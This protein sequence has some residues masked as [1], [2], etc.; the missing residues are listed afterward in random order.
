MARSACTALRVRP[1][2]LVAMAACL[3]LAAAPVLAAPGMEV[4]PT[5]ATRDL[6]GPDLALRGPHH[7]VAPRTQVREFMG[8][9]R[10]TT[11]LGDIDAVG[12]ADL[13]DRIGEAPALDALARLE[14]SDA[15]KG[16][17]E[18]S[19]RN[20][21][22]SARRVV[23]QP[24]ETI[25]S[26]P[27]GVGRTLL[28]GGR[29]VRKVALD[30]ADAVTPGD[31]DP[32]QD[33]AQAKTD[34]AEKNG[35][36]DGSDR[37]SGPDGAKVVR[38]YA[39]ELA[40]VNR[41]RRRIAQSLGIDPYP[42]S[43]LVADKLESLAWAG[44]AGGASLDLAL[45][46]VSS[47]LRNTVGVVRDVDQLAWDLP[48]ADVRHQLEKRLRARGLAGRASRDWLRNR[49]FTP[50]TQLQ[51]VALLE[52]L[53]LRDGEGDLLAL[54]TQ[55]G[56]PDHARFLVRQMRLLS[57][58]PDRRRLRRY[59]TDDG[60]LW[61]ARDDG[62]RVIPLPVDYLSWTAAIADASPLP[63]GAIAH[64]GRVVLTGRASARAKSEL[65]R[66]GWDA[67]ERVALAQAAP[68]AAQAGSG[69]P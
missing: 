46:G 2:S 33:K 19:A 4:E 16:A 22:E 51:F 31:D 58:A 38:D 39:R 12:E 8:R 15:F 11:A 20:T 35:G 6:V 21:V 49:A 68:T 9:Y 26:L 61:A 17:L 23:T 54:A 18:S 60:L 40:G 3:W 45:A 28:A 10:M 5:L 69:A 64:Q 55:A 14:R 47:G 57:A 30:I 1:F 44:A 62:Q 42:Q 66:R 63:P 53:D 43:P 41:A 37:D 65:R 50:S 36:Q 56:T 29:R 52:T 25:A 13:R 59:G 24:G 48:P 7:R 34:G 32:A 27:A 67:Q